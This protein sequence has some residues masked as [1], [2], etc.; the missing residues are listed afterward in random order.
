[1]INICFKAW[2]KEKRE[3]FDV[4]VID[5]NVNEVFLDKFSDM[6]IISGRLEEVHFWISFN[7]VILCQFT[8]LRD[9][10]GNNVFEHDVV[11]LA[12]GTLFEV[13]R[14]THCFKLKNINTK[15]VIDINHTSF[16]KEFVIKGNKFSMFGLT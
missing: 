16:D 13:F 15:H 10:C 7:D 14:E 5:M 2:H 6:A 11:S 3:M 4:L 1:M 12:D 9:M 8:N